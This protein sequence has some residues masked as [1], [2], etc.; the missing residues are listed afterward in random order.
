MSS[1]GKSLP[2]ALILDLLMPDIS[3][4]EI[5]R[6]L[7][8]EPATLNLPVLVYTSKRL[9]EAEAAQLASWQAKVIRKED[10]ATRLS[11]KPFLDWMKSLGLTHAASNGG[12][13]V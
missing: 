7:R 9:S 8:A 12:V 5:L 3:G 11:A 10:V 6:L 4:F 13:N 1:L 2:D